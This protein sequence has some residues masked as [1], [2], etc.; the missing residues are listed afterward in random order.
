MLAA[1]VVVASLPF[2]VL[3]ATIIVFSGA[4]KSAQRFIE[5]AGNN[6]YLVKTEPNIPREKIVF[7]QRLSLAEVREIKVF[8]KQYYQMLREKYA[9]LKLTYNEAFE[10]PALQPAAWAD[11]TL[12]EE[13]RVVVNS[14]SPVI[15]SLD[16]KSVV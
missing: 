9:S 3:I 8:E 14:S 6:S 12:P 10:V 7:S 16:R 11:K 4:E 13:Q 1:S 2:A 5:K 15:H